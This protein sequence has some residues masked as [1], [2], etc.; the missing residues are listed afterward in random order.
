[1]GAVG[2][3]VDDEGNLSETR[4]LAHPGG[5]LEAWDYRAQI[6]RSVVIGDSV[7]TVSAKGIMKS[8]LVSLQEQAWL[9]F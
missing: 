8:E 1:M 6:L 5:E 7:Y 3:T 9:G 4:R 2:L